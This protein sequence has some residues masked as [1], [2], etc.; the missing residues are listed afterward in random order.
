MNRLSSL[1]VGTIL[2]G[3]PSGLP[4]FPRRWV[5][6][7]IIMIILSGVLGWG[8]VRISQTVFSPVEVKIVD[9]GGH[10]PLPPSLPTSPFR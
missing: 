7:S 10:R 8:L 6:L 4:R 2:L 9:G 1:P 3:R 5:I